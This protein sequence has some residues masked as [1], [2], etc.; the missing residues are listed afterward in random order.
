MKT[1]VTVA[2]LM[3][4]AAFT[5]CNQGM[6]GG[7]GSTD[8]SPKDRS[9]ELGNADNTFTLTVPS[10]LPL[11][12][13]SIKEGRTANITIG[14][15][16]GKSFQQ[17]VTLRFEGMPAGMTIDPAA[18][19]I[20]KN[21][22]EV[23]LTLTATD[24]AALGD[25]EIKVIGHPATGGDATNSFKITVNKEPTFTVSSPSASIKQGESKAVTI[26][27]SREKTFN[28]DVSFTFADLPK[29]TTIEPANPVIKHGDTEVKLMLK[30]DDDAALG[31]FAAKVTGHP[32]KGADASHDFKITVAKK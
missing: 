16:R 23:N 18:P 5:A 1:T 12:S 11:W 4:L 14:I 7:P 25:F 3:S 27:I 8:P 13:T 21:Q 15:N 9:Y 2:I 29:G 6:P 22:T 31:E 30:S 19:E 17:N 26:N 32:A 10:S 24:A 28:E 20:K